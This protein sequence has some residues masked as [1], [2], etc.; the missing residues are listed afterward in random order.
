MKRKAAE[1]TFLE[2]KIERWPIERLIPFAKNSRTHS[3][4]QIA[5]IAGSIAA[6]GFVN[7][8][9]VG[10][11]QV[12]I[13]GHA[14]VLAARKLGLTEVPVI[15]LGHLSETQ[16]RALVIAD[17]RLAL[18]AGWDESM[19]ALEL[20]ALREEDFNLDV[21]GF[22]DEEL[23]RLLAEQDAAA[24]FTDED[25]VPQVQETACT[26]IGEMWLLGQHR[27][28]C[29]DATSMDVIEKVLDGGL[30]DMVFCDP[31]YSVGYVG[32]TSRKLTIKNDDLG[33]GFYDFLRKACANMI[34]ACKGAIYIC[35]SSSELHT[36]YRAFTDAGGHWSTFV[37]WAKHH[38]TLG[39]SD[40][41]RMYEPI[42][43]G[44]S[45]GTQH[46][47]CGD[48]DQG[49]V[50]FIKRPMANLEHP[51]MKPVELVERA[52]RNSSKTRDTVF[53]PFGGSG[54]TII[55]CEKAGRQARLIELDPQYV[56]T[57]V[58]RWQAFTG[59]VAKLDGD[60]R[61]FDEVTKERL[62]A[63][64]NPATPG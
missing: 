48:R 54:T 15:V 50:W 43:Y 3:D 45:E 22:E 5:E 57:A 36:L 47:W 24:G 29:G 32:K 40:Y 31:P 42:L 61:T 10:P 38:F 9:L 1:Q 17:N 59:K 49:D 28:L 44:W 18:N 4:A 12:I 8:V 64:V 2:L 58:R 60:G 33:A 35:M 46:F 11:D 21:L 39:R 23:A 56:D 51:T 34:T 37:I 26:A 19:L 20:A 63:A 25:E 62:K 41:Q 30:A 53:D 6:F 14:R 55:A 16:R 13:A 27:L 52:L 7:P